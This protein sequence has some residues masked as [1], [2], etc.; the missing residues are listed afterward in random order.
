[1]EESATV[2]FT[3]HVAYSATLTLDNEET[4]RKHYFFT[5]V[6]LLG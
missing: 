6:H 4:L 1:L 2:F 5:C 3:F